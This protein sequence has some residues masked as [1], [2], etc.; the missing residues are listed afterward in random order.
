MLKRTCEFIN[1]FDSKIVLICVIENP[2]SSI[3]D[4]KEYP[5]IQQKLGNKTLGKINNILLKKELLQK[6]FLK[7]G[8]MITK[9]KK[10]VK[11]GTM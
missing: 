6:N 4:H 2:Y 9:I 5:K 11:T 7:E 10:V 1:V 3:L 8:N